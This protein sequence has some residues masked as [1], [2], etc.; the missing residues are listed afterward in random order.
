MYNENEENKKKTRKRLSK[1]ELENSVVAVKLA[2]IRKQKNKQLYR[3]VLIPT[4]FHPKTT[5]ETTIITIE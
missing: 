5:T 3:I 2:I 4:S 1:S